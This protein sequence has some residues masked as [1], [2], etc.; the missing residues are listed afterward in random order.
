MEKIFFEESAYK[1]GLNDRYLSSNKSCNVLFNW[2]DAP[3]HCWSSGSQQHF[4]ECVAD[5]INEN[6]PQNKKLTTAAVCKRY[7]RFRQQT[8]EQH[9]RIEAKLWKTIEA[10]AEI[11]VSVEY[12]NNNFPLSKI[13][14]EK[15]D[16]IWMQS[17]KTLDLIFS[18][19]SRYT[20][21]RKDISAYGIWINYELAQLVLKN[22]SIDF[23]RLPIELALT[24][25]G[26]GQFLVLAGA[27]MVKNTKLG[28]KHQH[29]RLKRQEI[30]DSGMVEEREDLFILKESV[31][32]SSPSSA[33]SVL[34]G[35]NINGQIY[36]KDNRGRTFRELH[37]D[38][39]KI[40]IKRG[41]G[42]PKKSS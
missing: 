34:A 41:P 7:Q 13:F 26:H 29:I 1:A 20:L 19:N 21:N 39:D 36:W 3:N 37:P 4:F 9:L 22:W 24:Q 38:F 35:I 12:D 23:P 27:Q 10:I 40:K 25:N 15:L 11:P 8:P 33:A 14:Q 42:R 31:A 6:N 5:I 28:E 17:H 16:K 18:T 32:F 30:I 2:F